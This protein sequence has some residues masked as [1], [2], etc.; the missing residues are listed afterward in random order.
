MKK[1]NKPRINRVFYAR[2]RMN[3]MAKTRGYYFYDSN[4]SKNRQRIHENNANFNEKRVVKGVR[5][6]FGDTSPNSP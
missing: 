2:L 5:G 1:E 6:V 4:I 3:V